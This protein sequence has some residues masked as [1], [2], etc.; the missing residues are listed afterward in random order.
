VAD[1]VR[2]ALNEAVVTAATA[3]DADVLRDGR[4][5]PAEARLDPGLAAH[6]GAGR[7]ERTEAR[8]GD[9]NGTRERRWDPRVG[10]PGVA[11]P[12]VRD[13]G[14]LPVLPEPRPRAERARWAVVQ[15][16]DVLGV[17]TRRGDDLVEALGSGGI[18]KSPVGRVCAA[19]DAEVER[20]ADA[21]AGGGLPLPLARDAPFPKVRDGERV[22]PDAVVVASAVTAA[23]RREVP[24]F[25][26][27]PG[28]DGACWEGFLRGP[29]GR[30]R[31]DGRG[32]LP[33][34]GPGRGG[35]AAGSTSCATRGRWC[36]R[37][38]RQWS[39]PPSAPSSPSRRRTRRARNGRRWRRA[40][41]R[42]SHA[43][44]R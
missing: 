17:S 19:L 37:G 34:C 21:A 10:T 41:A 36:R 24:G 1:A 26:V 38:G 32:R 22:V 9:R 5:V 7:G 35:S 42:A 3:P 12:R 23:G 20:G 31:R 29:G 40:S 11:V 27:G 25:E 4:R 18:S 15:E 16:A 6:P 2:V 39:P 28:E 33:R 8:G 43:A 14:F 44:R 30:G 13:G